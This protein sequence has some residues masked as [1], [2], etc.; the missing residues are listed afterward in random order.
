[1]P[2]L[3]LTAATLAVKVDKQ[4]REELDIPIDRVIFWTDSTIVLRYIA[5]TSKRFQTFVANR[6][7]IIH[8][9]SSPCQWRHVST[10][11]NP[12]DLASRG[13]SIGGT[14][15]AECNLKFWFNGPD[16]LWQDYRSWPEQ[17]SDLPEVNDTD[18][19]V[20]RNKAN[21]GAVIVSENAITE[22]L[23]RLIR[24]PSCWYRL[25]KSVAWLLRFKQYLL[26]RC[27]K[28]PE[29]DVPRGPLKVKEIEQAAVEIVKI[30]QRE[31]SIN[32]QSSKERF[33]KLSPV[34]SEDIVKV[35]GR[36]ERSSLPEESKHPAILACNHHVTKL[37]VRYY[38]VKEGHAGTTQTLAAIRQKYWI[39]KG[40][41]TVK[42]I[43]N[44]CVAC[45]RRNQPPGKQIMAPLPEARVTP[46]EPPFSSV[47][48]D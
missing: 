38:H 37:I 10:K 12:A 30:T 43:I 1:M 48:I 22:S 36:L 31:A 9:A 47:G 20:K 44:E 2:R 40:P 39:V 26:S 7:Q 33:A 23:S 34:I 6:L 21:V 24:R 46:G 45:R 3:E 19:E 42:N 13:L 15:R 27:G 17:P 35:G 18:V 41:S 29:S 32:K 14:D 16:F 5:N 25:Q 28:V 8:D 11:L 4:I